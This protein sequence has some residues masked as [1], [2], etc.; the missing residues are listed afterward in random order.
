MSR[1]EDV[2]EKH[3]D[4][5]TILDLGIDL[6]ILRSVRCNMVGPQNITFEVMT[7]C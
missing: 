7:S 3:L 5:T 1:R 2:N 6:G 4:G